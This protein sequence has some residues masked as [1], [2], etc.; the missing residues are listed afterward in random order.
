VGP[1]FSGKVRE[2]P[3]RREREWGRDYETKTSAPRT[4]RGQMCICT[5]RIVAYVAIDP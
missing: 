1:R 2:E 3:Q 4:K 5:F